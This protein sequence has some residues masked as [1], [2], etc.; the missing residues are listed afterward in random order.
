MMNKPVA[1]IKISML[2]VIITNF[3][4]CKVKMAT[5][6]RW[7]VFNTPPLAYN[8]MHLPKRKGSAQDENTGLNAWQILV[9]PD[10]IKLIT[11]F[12][13]GINR[14]RFKDTAYTPY[15]GKKHQDEISAFSDQYTLLVL[16]SVLI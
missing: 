13:N 16:W 11:Q 7:F 12:T 14:Q 8:T 5:G 4:S 1:N 6:K 10:V 15:V 9:N 2:I 3:S